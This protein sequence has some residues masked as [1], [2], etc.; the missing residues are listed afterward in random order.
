MTVSITNPETLR[1]EIAGFLATALVGSGLPAQAVYGYEK[2][3]FDGQSPVVLVATNSEDFSRHSNTERTKGLYYFDVLI[4]VLYADTESN[5]TPAD[6]EDRLNLVLKTTMDAILNNQFT[7]SRSIYIDG[8][9]TIN[10][11]NVGGGDYRMERLP[12][13]VEV[14]N[15]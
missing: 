4:F 14:F 5:W 1:D 3:D 6:C 7:P 8:K 13:R 9:T 11:A 12:L 10:P 2:D 15:G